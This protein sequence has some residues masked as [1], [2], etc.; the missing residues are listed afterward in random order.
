[1]KLLTGL[2]KS[3]LYS[4]ASVLLLLL[5]VLYNDLLLAD[6]FSHVFICGFVAANTLTSSPNCEISQLLAV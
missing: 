3:S 2:S 1:M 6:E 5:L 4:S